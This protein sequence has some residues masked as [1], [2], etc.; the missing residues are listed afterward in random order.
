MTRSFGLANSS[1]VCSGTG[2]AFPERSRFVASCAIVGSSASL[3][4][5]RYGVASIR[6]CSGKSWLKI[7]HSSRRSTKHASLIEF[8]IK[9]T[10]TIPLTDHVIIKAIVYP[11]SS[12]FS[13]YRYLSHNK[14][15][16]K[17]NIPMTAR[18]NGQKS[19]RVIPSEQSSLG[20]HRF[21][22]KNFISNFSLH[23]SQFP[24]S[25]FSSIDNSQVFNHSS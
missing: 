3:S 4:C 7:L 23:I 5:I 14:N 2:E 1:R 11:L 16:I 9:Q 18:S 13:V 21:L 24:S 19:H 20:D 25:K 10:I 6:S 12:S 15:T 17:N 8:T 22:S